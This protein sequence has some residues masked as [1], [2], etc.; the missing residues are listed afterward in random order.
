M[1]KTLDQMMLEAIRGEDLTPLLPKIIKRLGAKQYWTRG[2]A[3]EVLSQAAKHGYDITPAFPQ[4]AKVLT[5]KDES[6]RTHAAEA[7]TYHYAYKENWNEI[8][9]LL[10][11]GDPRLRRGA[12]NALASVQFVLKGKDF[13]P[14]I[15]ALT[16]ALE[17][18][19][20][21]VKQN[22]ASALGNAALSGHDISNAFPALEKASVSKDAGVREDA[23]EA[24]VGL[25]F[26]AKK[27]KEIEKL[28]ESKES[29]I[30]EITA[31]VLSYISD[32]GRDIAP[33]VP[34]LQRSLEDKDPIKEEAAYALC[35][36]FLKR[37]DWKS[38]EDLLEAEAD[39]V[40]R[41]SAFVLEN[42]AELG[43]SKIA[44][45]APALIAALKDQ[46]EETRRHAVQALKIAVI[47]ENLSSA[48]PLL[49]KASENEGARA[50][51]G[52]AGVLTYQWAKTKEANKVE[53]LLYHQDQDIKNGV[54]SSLL[55]L[56]D[57]GLFLSHLRSCKLRSFPK[58]LLASCTVADHGYKISLYRW[59]DA[60][61]YFIY[62]SY[63]HEHG[64]HD[65]TDYYVQAE[66]KHSFFYALEKTP[67][68][69]KFIRTAG[70]ARFGKE[71]SSYVEMTHIEHDEHSEY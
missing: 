47:K 68:V 42:S 37:E 23:L 45:A 61:R 40:R 33:L 51:F 17:D 49:L 11:N 22:A 2:R 64:Y 29:K 67:E 31:R 39:V 30:R 9:K 20:T 65:E 19:N 60:N 46:D 26:N 13:S 70:Y 28:L 32:R 5:D 57:K 35:W 6:A 7:F 36:H 16:Q 52:A 15:P 12:S 63:G 21:E 59:A 4:L 56:A 38:I 41:I 10:K 62:L 8:E 34:A 54:L 48:I 1:N 44:P 14:I 25:R 53:E 3:A 27:L 50:R 58:T 66:G 43:K 69:E 24:I 71:I 55:E 18:K